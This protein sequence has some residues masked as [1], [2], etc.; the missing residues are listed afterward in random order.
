M[1][2]KSKQYEAKKK[3]LEMSLKKYE[4]SYRYVHQ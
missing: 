2:E 3:E 1:K 4:D